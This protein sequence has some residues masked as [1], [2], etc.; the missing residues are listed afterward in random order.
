M[1]N[2]PMVAQSPYYYILHTHSAS[3]NWSQMDSFEHTHTYTTHYSPLTCIEHY[4]IT[5]A[6]V[7]EYATTTIQSKLQNFYTYICTYLCVHNYVDR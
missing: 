2:F 3:S 5:T 7:Y 4:K 6:C 1:L